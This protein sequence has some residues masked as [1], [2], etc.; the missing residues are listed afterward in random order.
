MYERDQKRGDAQVATVVKQR[1]E[2]AT[3]TR[4][5]PD[6]QDDV[7]QENRTRPEGSNNHHRRIDGML[8]MPG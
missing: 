4:Q 3:E 1:D 7:K 2:T 6:A 8:A 5:R